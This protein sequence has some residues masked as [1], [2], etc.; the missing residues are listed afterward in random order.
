MNTIKYIIITFFISSL[1]IHCSYADKHHIITYNSDEFKKFEAG[2]AVKLKQAWDI[3]KKYA[4]DKGEP[5]AGWLFFVIDGN[6]VFTSMFRPKIPEASTGGI[7]VN[8]ETGEVKETDADAYIR[9]KDAYN[10]DGHPFY[11]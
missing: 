3:Q 7:W 1:L 8:S 5:P 4:M 11:F 10:G 9:Y 6:Y 2:A